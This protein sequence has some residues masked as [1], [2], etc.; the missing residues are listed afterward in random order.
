MKHIF[1]LLVTVLLCFGGATS[2][3]SGYPV[4][5][6]GTLHVYPDKEKDGWIYVYRDQTYYDLQA[7]ADKKSISK[8]FVAGRKPL[9]EKKALEPVLKDALGEGVEVI[10][11]RDVMPPLYRHPI[12]AP[13]P[14]LF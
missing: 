14:I 5:Q 9:E 8:V 12:M 10:Y 11:D 6:E 13:R 2:C 7:V 4:T 3:S 1:L